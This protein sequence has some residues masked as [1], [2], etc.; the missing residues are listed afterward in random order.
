MTLAG[1]MRDGVEDT[2]AEAEVLRAEA[3]AYDMAGGR[4]AAD[5]ALA[6]LRTLGEPELFL[7]DRRTG[8]L[9]EGEVALRRGRTDAAID[10][11][12][13][14]AA[15]LPRH[16]W[17]PPP[18]WHVPIWFALGSAHLAAGR[19]RDA[20]ESFRRILESGSGRNPYPIE[21]VRSHYFLGR[22]ARK[23]GDAVKA[24]EYFA[25]FADLWKDGDLDLERVKEARADVS[26]G[27]AAGGRAVSRP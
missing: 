26:I 9:A 16:G 27:S 3:N 10:A 17:F 11:L 23:R 18:S 24:R 8:F 1:K 14:A 21:Y 12:T 13:R 15:L 4:D 7:S 19:D 25:R 22:I 2:S 6:R 5:R 20:E